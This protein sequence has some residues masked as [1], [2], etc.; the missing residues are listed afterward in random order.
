MRNPNRSNLTIQNT[1]RRIIEN[2]FKILD[3]IDVDHIIAKF[4]GGDQ[5]GL[6]LTLFVGE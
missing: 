6:R 4:D 3:N 2:Y 1:L 5:A